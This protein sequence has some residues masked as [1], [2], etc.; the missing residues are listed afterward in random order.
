MELKGR[1]MLA[2]VLVMN[3]SVSKGDQSGNIQQVYI[4]FRVEWRWMG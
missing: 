2:T 4:G 3:R 1:R